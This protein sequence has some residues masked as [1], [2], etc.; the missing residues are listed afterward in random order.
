MEEVRHLTR[1]H[2]EPLRPRWLGARAA[3]PLVALLTASRA[4]VWNRTIGD[5]T[6]EDLELLQRDFTKSGPGSMKARHKYQ[7]PLPMVQAFIRTYSKEFDLVVDP[8]AGGGTVAL[9]AIKLNRLAKTYEI[10]IE[11]LNIAR[12]NLMTEVAS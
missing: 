8:F 1:T 11:S 10:D 12:K 3:S 2:D 7:S 6:A 4:L 9:C 5:P